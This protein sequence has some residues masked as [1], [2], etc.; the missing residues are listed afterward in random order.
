MEPRKTLDEIEREDRRVRLVRCIAAR[1][2][3]FEGRTRRVEDQNFRSQYTLTYLRVKGGTR[4]D[5]VGGWALGV[6]RFREERGLYRSR[7]SRVQNLRIYKRVVDR[8]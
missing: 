4:W 1:V 3:V 2:T 6:L 7:C 8:E 5:E